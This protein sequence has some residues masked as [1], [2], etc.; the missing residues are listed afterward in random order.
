MQ[1]LINQYLKPGYIYEIKKATI[2]KATEELDIE[3][4]ANFILPESE[5]EVISGQIALHMPKVS[6]VN[7]K[8]IIEDLLE[9]FKN[10]KQEV[11]P[12]VNTTKAK[13]SYRRNP[14]GK[15]RA[16][17]KILAKRIKEDSVS[18]GKISEIGKSY[19]FEGRVI[20]INIKQ[21]KNER[22]IVTFG[23]YD[24]DSAIAIK[25]FTNQDRKE[26]LDQAIKEG[27]A[28][29]IRGDLEWDDFSKENIIQGKAIEVIQL[30]EREDTAEE[31]RVEL[32]LHTKMSAMDGLVNPEDAVK[33]AIKWGHAA[34]AIT[35]HGGVQTFPT[36]HDTVKKAKNKIKVIYGVEAYLIEAASEGNKEKPKHIILLAKNREGIKNLY[37][38]VSISHTEHFYKKPRIPKEILRENSEGLIIGS[39]CQE[40]E[41]FSRILEL[42]SSDAMSSVI[43]EE[44]NLFEAWQKKVGG[45]EKIRELLDLYDYLEIQPR[46][47]NKFLIREGILKNEKQLEYI[48]RIIIDL[49]R[50]AKKPVVATG[51][52]HYLEPED[53]KFRQVIQAGMGFKDTYEGTGFHLRTTEEMLEEFSYLGEELAREVVIK[54][55]NLVAGWI[56]ELSP[57]SDKMCQ[58][59]YPDSEEILLEKC[60]SKAAEIYGSPLPKPVDERLQKELKAIIGNGYPVMYVISALLVE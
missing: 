50:K 55:T 15:S 46:S 34:I 30:P 40:G 33:T 57:I 9:E 11:Q 41:I 32:H 37:K 14:G 4:V 49:A 7:I 23:V 48:N 52:V 59:F 47:N 5:V 42:V 17:G 3:M 51:D 45:D 53:A 13:E 56:A 44:K 8:I 26:E 36:L 10:I 20:K 16:S 39:A 60:N 28:V 12:A 21:I 58:P 24:K 6:K 2:S 25:L 29:K 27:V 43:I 18:I 19:T 31:K 35:D 1:N 22:Y 54:N 38:I